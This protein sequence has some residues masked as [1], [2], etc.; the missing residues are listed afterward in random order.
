MSQLILTKMVGLEFSFR[1]WKRLEVYFEKQTHVK[2][3]KLKIQLKTIKKEKSVNE[4]LFEIKKIVDSLASIGVKISESNRIDVILDGLL[5]EFDSFVTA[6][7]SCLDSYS[8]VDIEALLLAQEERF[9]KHKKNDSQFMQANIATT[10]S[11]SDS[12][13]Y[14]RG[15]GNS[16]NFHGGF[17]PSRGRGGKSNYRD[18]FNANRR[19]FS[20]G[21]G[22]GRNGWNPNHPQCQLYGKFGHLVVNC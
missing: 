3:K 11:P 13:S 5:D 9:E 21:Q 12:Q 22:F 1:I 19:H 20:N 8:V 14:G 17:S 2:V 7:T 6:I 4:Y 15:R 16:S 10:S 18:N